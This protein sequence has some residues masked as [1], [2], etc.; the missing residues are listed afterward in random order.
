MTEPDGR[1]LTLG[2]LCAWL[3]ITE[4][5]A[6]KLVA[7]KAIPYRKVGRL[8]R[9]SAAEIEVWSRPPVP[10][11]PRATDDLAAEFTTPI[12]SNGARRCS[13]RLPKSLLD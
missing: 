1:L 9:F 10:A 7:R 12:R 6:R 2:E 4:R 11:A 3:N 5:H 8:L 13:Q